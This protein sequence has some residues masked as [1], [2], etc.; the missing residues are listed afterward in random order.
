[1]KQ[2]HLMIGNSP[3]AL[4]YY[5]AGYTPD[6]FKNPEAKKGR[7]LIEH[8]SAIQTPDLWMQLAGM[9]KIQQAL[10]R[11][12]ILNQFAPRHWITK[13][14]STFVKMHSLG[15]DTKALGESQ[16]AMDLANKNPESWV[17]KPQREGGGNNYFD[18]EMTQKL[19]IMSP[20][21][22]KAHVLM[23]RIRPRSHP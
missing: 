13:M 6:D 8:S 10:T 23:E 17:L 4:V 18:K 7:E 12:E 20:P 5:R 15:E 2:G 14:A 19:S 1:M 3:V 9:K 11:P 22:L 21:E 16:N